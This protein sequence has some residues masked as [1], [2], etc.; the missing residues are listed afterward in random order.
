MSNYYKYPTLFLEVSR[1]LKT[2]LKGYGIEHTLAERSLLR[3]QTM[4]GLEK[5]GITQETY[6][7]DN[8]ED[9]YDGWLIEDAM[10]FE[11]N[12]FYKTRYCL[13]DLR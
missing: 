5:A 8:F 11:I 12:N 13:T 9:L 7:L 4:K 2:L 3:D 1:S 6:S 10:N